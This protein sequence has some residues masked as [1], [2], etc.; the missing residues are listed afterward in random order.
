MSILGKCYTAILNK[1]L[2]DWLEDNNKTEET[3]AGF[4]RGH[5]TTDHVFSLYAITQKYLS[6]RGGKLY[7]VFIDL[8]KAFDSVKREGRSVLSL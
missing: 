8:R 2:Y 6:K 1:P 5:S 3:Q 7:V 4:G